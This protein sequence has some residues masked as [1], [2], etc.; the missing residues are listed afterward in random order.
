MSLFNYYEYGDLNPYMEK[1]NDSTVQ[2][3]RPI[4]RANRHLK[5]VKLPKNKI[6]SLDK[7]EKIIS[8]QHTL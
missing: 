3:L 5:H 8:L 7:S 6:N 1:G 2:S 4:N